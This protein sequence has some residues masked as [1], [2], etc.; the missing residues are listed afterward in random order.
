MR[1]PSKQQPLTICRS[2]QKEKNWPCLSPLRCKCRVK[3]IVRLP[4]LL[5]KSIQVYCVSL[6]QAEERL[7]A[8]SN[9]MCGYFQTATCV[10]QG[11]Y[12]AALAAFFIFILALIF[13]CL[14]QK[15]SIRVFLITRTCKYHLCIDVLPQICLT[16]SFCRTICSQV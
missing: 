1:S 4:P 5:C 2:G 11:H 15:S 16:L 3:T 8:T 13:H 10:S 6:L 14:S 7:H 9:G 12:Q